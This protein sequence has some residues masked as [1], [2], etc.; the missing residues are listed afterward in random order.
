MMI[1]D[2]HHRY[3]VY[4]D[5]GE[6][7]IPVIKKDFKDETERILFSQTMNKLRGEHDKILDVDLVYSLVK[8]SEENLREYMALTA[9]DD[10]ATVLSYLKRQHPDYSLQYNSEKDMTNL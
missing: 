7:E 10:E 6:T 9:V 8:G 5:K 2:G 4:E 3:R 1:A